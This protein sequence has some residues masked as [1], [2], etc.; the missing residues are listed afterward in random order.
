MTGD[1]RGEILSDSLELHEGDVV[2]LAVDHVRLHFTVEREVDHVLM[3]FRR[4]HSLDDEDNPVILPVMG[5]VVLNGEPVPLEHH[6]P[7]SFSPFQV[8]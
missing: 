3:T 2:L 8:L 7:V 6:Q 5:E 4:A 1:V